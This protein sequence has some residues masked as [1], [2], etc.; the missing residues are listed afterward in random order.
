MTE[1]HRF[2]DR[3]QPIGGVS[4]GDLDPEPFSGTPDE[5]RVADRLGGGD[6]HQEPRSGRSRFDSVLKA[7]LEPSRQRLPRG[8]Q[9]A[10]TTG[11][12]LD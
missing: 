8:V 5:H 1:P 9:Q 6:Q 7:L 10:E 11:K 4:R 2:L 3:E 12:L